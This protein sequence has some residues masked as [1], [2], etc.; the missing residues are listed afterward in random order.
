MVDSISK[1]K[2]TDKQDNQ[3]A[4]PNS[5][6]VPDEEGI[7][8]EER[9]AILGEIE[10]IT[11][12]QRI[13]VRSD[14]FETKAEQRGIA[15][16]SLVN[17]VALGL[18]VLLLPLL[19]LFFSRQQREIGVV[20]ELDTS[21][22]GALIQQIRDQYETEL[23]NQEDSLVTIR[24]QL[25]DVE[26]QRDA[27]LGRVD[28]QVL[29][30][31][32]QLETELGQRIALERARLEALSITIAELESRLQAFEGAE[33]IK[34]EQQLA[35]FQADLIRQQQQLLDE[36]DRQES[37]FESEL[38]AAKQQR[39]L[40]TEN[41]RQR[42]LELRRQAE[43]EAAGQ[44]SAAQERLQDL[45][46]IQ[47]LER[48]FNNGISGFYNSIVVSLDRG[49]IDSAQRNIDLLRAY[50]DQSVIADLPSISQRRAT[51]LEIISVLETLVDQVSVEGS[52]TADLIAER[53]RQTEAAAAIYASAQ[54]S[55]RVGD[56]AQALEG[57][58]TI[59]E[60]LPQSQ[61]LQEIPTELRTLYSSNNT[62][63]E[64]RITQLEGRSCA[65]GGR[66]CACR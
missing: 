47:D 52:E 10:Q 31:Q 38:D 8:A 60:D 65:I 35:E 4:P 57:Y 43:V 50:L 64:G 7:S 58:L 61:Q 49:D 32:Q 53:N 34:L 59:L 56:T 33:R 20:A 18:L 45:N 22:Q 21:A 5:V 27:L 36:L 46:R 55:L 9:Q 11:A 51:D 2:N 3:V 25:A 24:Q 17:L 41:A 63:Y 44:I 12:A 40:L 26:A 54:G 37:Q 13:V 39:D 42:E 19:W 62:G 29:E 16:P 28:Q 14:T 48:Q 66:S 30:Q 6:D 1:G 15:L 23:A